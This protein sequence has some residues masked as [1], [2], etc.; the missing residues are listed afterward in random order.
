MIQ[1]IK[2]CLKNKRTIFYK[3]ALS[4]AFDYFRDIE[5]AD[6]ST[7]EVLTFIKLS[8]GEW[9]IKVQKTLY[10]FSNENNVDVLEPFFYFFTLQTYKKLNRKKNYSNN[11][12]N[13]PYSM[14][15]NKTS[16]IEID[17]LKQKY[18]N[19]FLEALKDKKDFNKFLIK[20][21]KYIK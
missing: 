8:K 7:K 19:E 16:N 21:L 10:K 6:L 9:D 1:K 15:K 3:N 2:K 18:Y 4:T 14:W 13:N 12:K 5:V 11:F 17:I 20:F